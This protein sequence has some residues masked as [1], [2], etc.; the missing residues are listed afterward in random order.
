[1][2][3]NGA[4][5]FCGRAYNSGDDE[6]VIINFANNGWA[7]LILGG[8]SAARSVFYFKN[9]GSAPF[10]RYNNG[11]ST[12]DMYHPAKGGTIALTSDLANYLP[13]SGGTLTG[14]LVIS[15]NGKTTTFGC[16][17]SSYSH[18]STNADAGHWFN[19]NVSVQGNIYAGNSY[20]K[21]VL[22]EE[23]YTNY[24]PTKTGGGASG[25]WGINISGKAANLNINNSANLSDCL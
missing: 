22:T 9:D 2:T 14:L 24:A 4:G 13:L 20:N 15:T 16:Q 12:Y 7:G 1:M 19:K 11:T 5:Y 3:V 17:N 21:L 8:P 10:W 23:N 25:T 18:Y 6:G